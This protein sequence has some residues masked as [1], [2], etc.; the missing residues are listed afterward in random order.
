MSGFNQN[1]NINAGANGA[2]QNN[3]GMNAGVNAGVNPYGA[4]PNNQYNMNGGAGGY[5]GMGQQN[6]AYNMNGGAGG[7]GYAGNNGMGYGNPPAGSGMNQQG[8]YGQQQPGGY[9]QQ[10]GFGNGQQQGYG[11][12]Q[13]GGYG[14]F[15]GVQNQFP[16]GTNSGYNPNSGNNV[17]GFNPNAINTGMGSNQAQSNNNA[18]AATGNKTQNESQNPATNSGTGLPQNTKNEGQSPSKG[19]GE[20]PATGVEEKKG[21]GS[22]SNPLNQLVQKSSAGLGNDP[23]MS[24]VNLGAEKQNEVGNSS[25][26]NQN[27]NAQLNENKGSAVQNNQNPTKSQ[28]PSQMN[29]SNHVEKDQIKELSHKSQKNNIISQE[30]GTKVEVQ[31]ETK[32]EPQ[33]FNLSKLNFAGIKGMEDSKG[34]FT[35]GVITANVN[36]NIEFKE[37]EKQNEIVSE[38]I[39]GQI[40]LDPLKNH[41]AKREDSDDED[42]KPENKDKEGGKDQKEWMNWTNPYF[43]PQN[44]ALGEGESEQK[45]GANPQFILNLSKESSALK[46]IVEDCKTTNSKYVDKNFKADLQSIV[47][48][49]AKEIKPKYQTYVWKRPSEMFENYTLCGD[50]VESNDVKQGYLGDC[51]F[52]CAKSAIAEHPERI[53]KNIISKTENDAGAYCVVLCIAGIWEEITLDD[54]F[55]CDPANNKPAFSQS[56]SNDLWVML[57]EKAWAKV[58]GGYLNIESGFTSE[59]L[60]SLTG[61]PVYTFF[62]EEENSDENWKM[63]L[64]GEKNN[65]IMTCSSMDIRKTGNDAADNETGLSGN[66]GYSLLSGHEVALQDG[67]VEKLVKL[68]N[69]W[70]RG[71]WKGA[72]SDKS[73]LWTP[74]LKQK[75]GI[76]DVDDGIF[77]MAFKD[78]QKYFNDFDVCY[79]HDNYILSSQKYKSL[80]TSPTVLTFT[81]TSPSSLYFMITQINKRM[82]RKEDH[83]SY[84]H[85]SLI[86][87]R[88]DGSKF[89]YVGDITRTDECAWFKAQCEPGEYIAYIMTP[90]KRKVNEFTFSI[91]GPEEIKFHKTPSQ[92][93]KQEFLTEVFIDKAKLAEATF[94][95]FA[96]RGNPDIEYLFQ[97]TYTSFN[98]FYF[99]NNSPSTTLKATI[100][101]DKFEDAYIFEPFSY[102]QPTIEVLP[103]SEKILLVR[104]NSQKS[105]MAV[106]MGA[107]FSGSFD[108]GGCCLI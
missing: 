55:P 66:H 35:P 56:R 12:G 46:N 70:G 93:L 6:L 85:L 100:F 8:G 107:T 74:E 71:E 3:P 65:Y 108:C 4:M 25:Q 72:W 24:P 61:A 92:L 23:K 84:S 1:A 87:A 13:Q 2:G 27:L 30:L 45:Q 86:V 48:Y 15:G 64:D 91:Y 26:Q 60:F 89:C 37:P 52:I 69:P 36:D 73:P 63:I 78:W 51:Y 16:G 40:N 49:G 22:T 9:G 106:R 79:Y 57:L 47:G 28:H 19:F 17:S 67:T 42:D 88:M 103:K 41:I 38:F 11:M 95:N 32:P 82:F 81:V 33:A 39:T 101:F 53:K 105:E 34:N 14:Q 68:R 94:K 21:Q 80:P 90:W 97:I 83:Y 50:G 29:R 43:Q 59:A 75:L 7:Y 58:H 18:G 31:G 54:L 10:P 62:V 98:I 102:P 96:S 99:R 44:K 5:G 20:N 104:F 76:K 77:F